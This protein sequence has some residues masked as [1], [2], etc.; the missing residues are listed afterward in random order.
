MGCVCILSCCVTATTANVKSSTACVK[1]AFCVMVSLLYH[2]AELMELLFFLIFHG[3]IFMLH[4]HAE[5]AALF[6]WMSWSDFKS[7][8]IFFFCCFA[9]WWVFFFFFFVI[10]FSDHV[11]SN[12]IR[13]QFWLYDTIENVIHQNWNGVSF[14]LVCACFVNVYGDFFFCNGDT[15]NGESNWQPGF[16]LLSNIW[17]PEYFL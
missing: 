2:I 6:D 4:L 15:N 8:L 11:T 14:F 1:I 7:W 3:V 12:I 9:I 5:Y 17:N 13:G 10:I 16:W